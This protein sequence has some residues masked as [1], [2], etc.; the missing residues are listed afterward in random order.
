MIKIL[1]LYCLDFVKM[2]WKYLE[3][4]RFAKKLTLATWWS[5]SASIEARWALWLSRSLVWRSNYILCF[6]RGDYILH[7]IEEKLY[8]ISYGGAI[9][10]RFYGGA[11]IF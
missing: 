11:I 4:K 8:F 9:Y 5:I 2:A 1:V 10:F 3:Y 6:F 7:F